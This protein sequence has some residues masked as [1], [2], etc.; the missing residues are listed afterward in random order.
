MVGLSDVNNFGG[1]DADAD[2]LLGTCFEDHE[3]YLAARNHER[4]LITGRK[5]SGKTAIFKK[6]LGSQSHEF[7]PSAI[8]FPIT[9]GNITISKRKL[10]YRKSN[11]IYTVGST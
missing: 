6:F 9:L 11:V 7:F 4:F 1:I 3:A 5:G 2:E 10:V 8:R